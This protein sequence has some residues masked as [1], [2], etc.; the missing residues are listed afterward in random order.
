MTLVLRR[1][2]SRFVPEWNRDKFWN[3]YCEG[4]YLGS[5]VEGMGR[6]DEPPHWDWV[7]QL[8]AGRYFNGLAHLS[9]GRAVTRQEAMAAYR[10]AWDIIRL[11][12]GDEGW[13]L[14]LEHMEWLDRRDSA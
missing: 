10:R 13:R 9:S 11:A 4:V 14:H 2:D 5:I 6:S 3:V 12:I 7:V 8:H 1:T